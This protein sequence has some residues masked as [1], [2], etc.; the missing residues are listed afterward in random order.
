MI[1]D[2]FGVKLGSEMMIA[3]ILWDKL[4]L[5]LNPLALHVSDETS[6]IRKSNKTSF[7]GCVWVD[8]AI[9]NLLPVI[10]ALADFAYF[11]NLFE[12]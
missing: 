3:I 10:P 1:M 7:K 9:W 12:Y 6:N 2:D 8:I 11:P 4:T 5:V